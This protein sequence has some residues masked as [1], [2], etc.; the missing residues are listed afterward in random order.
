MADR[1]IK[2]AGKRGPGTLYRH[3]FCEQLVAHFTVEPYVE[4]TL[5]NPKTGNEYKQR[6]PNRMPTFASFATSI[7]VSRKT[8]DIWRKA[9]PE[10]ATAAERAKALAEDMLVVNGLAGLIDAKFAVFVAKN[11]T[12]L[13]DVH[14]YKDLGDDDDPT[15]PDEIEERIARLDR[16]LAALRKQL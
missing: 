15:P 11:Y 1:L 5:L 2:E 6:V 14:E 3:E 4:L 8:I 7:G 16:E 12:D 13:K 10:F 9:H